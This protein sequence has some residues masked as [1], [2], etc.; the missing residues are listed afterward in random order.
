M[1]HSKKPKRRQE[2]SGGKKPIRPYCPGGFYSRF[3]VFSFC[4]YDAKTPWAESVSGKSTVDGIFENLRGIEGLRWS[5]ICQALGGRTKGTNSHY[6]E[7]FKMSEAA[8][9][10]AEEI[11]L[12]ENELF[13]LRLQGTVRLWGIVEPDGRFFVIWFDPDH[14]VYPVDP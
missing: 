10:R 2:I 5:E 14:L 1:A 8:R 7:V 3:P 11:R 9:R 12:D 6:I 4:R 13:S